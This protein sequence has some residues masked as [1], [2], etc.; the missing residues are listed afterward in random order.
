MDLILEMEW[1]GKCCGPGGC[2]CHCLFLHP[3]PLQE[4]V[5]TSLRNEYVYKSFCNKSLP[6]SRK[7]AGSN[8]YEFIGFFF[9]IYVI[10][11]GAL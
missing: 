3:F 7:V 1:K 11:P 10:F 9:P 2:V 8:P 4:A 5:R 6:S